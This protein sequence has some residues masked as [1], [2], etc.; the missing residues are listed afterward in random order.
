MGNNHISDFH[1][2][3]QA[4]E[5][6]H[7][8]IELNHERLGYFTKLAKT[9]PSL[10]LNYCCQPSSRQ[11]SHDN[12]SPISRNSN[13]LRFAYLDKIL[14]SERKRFDFD[15]QEGR[16]NNIFI[17]DW[18]D[19]LLYTSFLIKDGKINKNIIVTKADKRKMDL[20]AKEVEC[21]LT[22]AKQLGKVY[23]VTNGQL[24]WVE[25]SASRF[26]PS[27]LPLLSE[28]E[29]ISARSKFEDIMPDKPTL[30]KVQVFMEISRAY[31]KAKLTNLI[32]IGDSESEM[33]AADFMGRQFDQAFVKTVKLRE[34]PGLDELL[35]QLGLVNKSLETIFRMDRTQLIKVE[36]KK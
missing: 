17:F 35:K 11:P 21:I 3:S 7:K 22:K 26:M 33:T 19:T 9:N 31:N 8:P 16:A 34:N 27:L 30:W 23:I 13:Q 32:V 5:T 4:A 29:V 1:Q 24:G 36:K 15:A 10:S 18:D 25:L 28:I 12:T 6:A 20:I 14:S 2:K